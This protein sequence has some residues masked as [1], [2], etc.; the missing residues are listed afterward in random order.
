MG[1]ECATENEMPFS[2]AIA[3]FVEEKKPGGK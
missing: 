2:I 3:I 1:A